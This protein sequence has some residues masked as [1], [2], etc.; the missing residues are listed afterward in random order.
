MFMFIPQL[1]HRITIYTP[2]WLCAVTISHQ[3]QK[4]VLA[5][6]SMFLLYAIEFNKCDLQQ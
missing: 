5:I 3:R 2:R 4:Y 6:Q 1:T